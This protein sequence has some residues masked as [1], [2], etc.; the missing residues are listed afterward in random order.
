MAASTLLPMIRSRLF[1]VILVICL[2]PVARGAENKPNIVILL[3]DDLRCDG[4]GS[5]GHPVVKTPNVDRLVST[6]YIFRRA[7]TMGSMEGAVCLPSRTMLLTGMS[8]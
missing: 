1:V 6:G 3:A 4:L 7:Y 8:M 5:L 2:L